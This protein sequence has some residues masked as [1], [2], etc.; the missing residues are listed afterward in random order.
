MN[1]IYL[2]KN[3]YVV[4]KKIKIGNKKKF[5]Q[6]NT[7][8]LNLQNCKNCTQKSYEQILKIRLEQLCPHLSKRFCISYHFQDLSGKFRICNTNALYIQQSTAM[9]DIYNFFAEKFKHITNYCSRKELQILFD[10][11]LN[12]TLH[13]TQLVRSLECNTVQIL[14]GSGTLCYTSLH[15]FIF[16][17]LLKQASE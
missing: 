8:L 16:D 11:K 9:N 7:K 6:F 4:H 10:R 3:Q 1:F 2:C 13:F 14:L 15:I 12:S 5:K 17:A